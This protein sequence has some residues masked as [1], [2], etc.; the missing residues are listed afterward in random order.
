M[1][2][3]IHPPNYRTRPN[4]AKARV[5][6]GPNIGTDHPA[7]SHEIWVIVPAYNEG[8]RLGRTLRS[9]CV[10][11]ANV[12][13][14][15][16]GSHDDTSGVALRHPVWVLR[17]VINR[18]QGAALQTGLSFAL[19]RGAMVLV[20]FDADGQ[21]SPEEIERLVEPVRSGAVDVALGSRFLGQ[22]VGLPWSRWPECS[23][24]AC[25]LPG[26]FPRSGSRTPITAY[27]PSRATPRRGSASHRTAWPTHRRSSTRSRHTGCATARCR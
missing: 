21:H 14:V 19:E 1:R 20:T 6:S 23:S 8:G 13:V 15:D 24:W 22:A 10:G 27:G 4:R 5:R 18:G 26:C 2:G 25:C 9:L 16:D 3:M 11:H 17:H 7:G 12:V